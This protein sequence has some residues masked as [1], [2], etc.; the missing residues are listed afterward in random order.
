MQNAKG[1]G[2]WCFL[3]CVWVFVNVLC[4]IWGMRFLSCLWWI[5]N[6]EGAKCRGFSWG[7]YF[8]WGLHVFS[9]LRFWGDDCNKNEFKIQKHYT[10][11][12]W[13]GATTKHTNILRE[14][15]VKPNKLNTRK[16]SIQTRNIWQQ[17]RRGSSRKG[18]RTFAVRVRDLRLGC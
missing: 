6:F 14:M 4:W 16:T 3:N 1:C 8:A 9:F 18:K 7:L 13:T 15:Y 10:N 2:L 17:S 11:L 5:L 12:A